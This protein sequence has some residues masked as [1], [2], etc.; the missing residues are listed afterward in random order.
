[1]C[2]PS[3]HQYRWASE[4]LPRLRPGDRLLGR[5]CVLHS[6]W[7]CGPPQSRQAWRKRQ[8]GNLQRWSLNLLQIS[9][10]LVVNGTWVA[11]DCSMAAAQ[12]G[13]SDRKLVIWRAGLQGHT[14]EAWSSLRQNEQ[15][16]TAL[17]LPVNASL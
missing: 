11:D 6:C 14:A 17:A 9:S 12:E 3:T 2:G 4:P 13:I 1:M 8:R 16:A 7:G 15:R 10:E 5:C